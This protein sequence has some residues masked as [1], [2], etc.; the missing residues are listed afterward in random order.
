MTIN[1]F[2]SSWAYG[3]IFILLYVIQSIVVKKNYVFNI[4][5]KARPLADGAYNKIMQNASTTKNNNKRIA[6][7]FLKFLKFFRKNTQ[8]RCDG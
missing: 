1:Y 2:N 7:I 6:L 3:W 5:L 4:F 8:R